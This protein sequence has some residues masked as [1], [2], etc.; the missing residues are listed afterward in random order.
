[1]FT[2]VSRSSLRSDA[3]GG[4][5]KLSVDSSC[6]GTWRFY[7]P[8]VAN[9]APRPSLQG[10]IVPSA[11]RLP[12]PVRVV[13][14]PARASAPSSA[15][16]LSLATPNDAMLAARPDS[17]L[18]AHIVLPPLWEEEEGLASSF[19]LQ[20]SWTSEQLCPHFITVSIT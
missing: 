12:V 9:T 2:V 16:S 11:H 1:M 20:K 19:R 17:C 10:P 14:P 8:G 18:A 7:V 3:P 13:S 6:G 4:V 5:N 15:L